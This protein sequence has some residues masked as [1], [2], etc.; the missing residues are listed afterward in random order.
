[1]SSFVTHLQCSLTGEAYPA[2]E[3]HGRSR[4]GAPLLV[5][6]DLAAVKAAVPREALAARAD[7]FW[8]YRDLLPVEMEKNRVS[9]GEPLTPLI[10]APRIEALRGGGDLYVKDESRLPAGT[11]AARGV[12]LAVSM[13]KELR[14]KHLAMA[15]DSA[16]GAALAAYASRAGLRATVFCP[17]DAAALAGEIAFY[18]AGALLVRGGV[19]ACRKIV[20]DGIGK[21]G[22]VDVSALQEPYRIEGMKTL[23]FELA[24][25]LEWTLPDWIFS[26]ASDTAALIGLNK[27]FDELEAIGWIGAKRPR[28]I[29]AGPAGDAPSWDHGPVA[30]HDSRIAFEEMAREEG[31][32]LGPGGAA[33]YAAHRNAV[34]ARRVRRADRVVVVNDASGLR[35]PMPDAGELIDPA[36]PIDFTRWKIRT[37][38]DD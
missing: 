28:M 32:L 37:T 22:W 25:Q 14:L 24:E 2:R 6:Y 17:D 30:D 18:G 27:A 38:G 31:L 3:A 10:R 1:M 11:S 34:A 23:G 12:A 9:L 35:T 7:G 26:S 20:S 29:A 21:A 15:A 13:A 16:E 19:D 5:R 8:R 4:A 36:A 33:A